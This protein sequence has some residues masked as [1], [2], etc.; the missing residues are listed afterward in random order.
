MKLITKAQQAILLRQHP[1]A[2]SGKV[3]DLKVPLKLFALAS[4]WTAFIISQDPSNND[5]L[6]GIVTGPGLTT[7]LGYISLSEVEKLRYMGIPR[8]ERDQY[9]STLTAKEVW[10][11]ID[12]NRHM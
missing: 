6:Y 1:I 7:E 5:L 11:N 4:G 9:Y 8:V 3:K 12:N 10:A 2:A